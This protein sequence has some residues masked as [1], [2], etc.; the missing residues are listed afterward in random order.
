MSARQRSSSSENSASASPEVRAAQLA[1]ALEP[2]LE[3]QRRG[4][5]VRE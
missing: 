5:L 4:D 3:R 2:A 1:D